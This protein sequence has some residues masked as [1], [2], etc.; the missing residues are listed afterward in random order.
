MDIGIIIS[1][2]SYLT[3]ASNATTPKAKY[4]FLKLF[5]RK[6]N[7]NNAIK[8]MYILSAV[9]INELWINLGS[10]TNNAAPNNE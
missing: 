8:K 5:E 6:R 3:K 2:P 7:S 9:P 1:N 10:K 4:I